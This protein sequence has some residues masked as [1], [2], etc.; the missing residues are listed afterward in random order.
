M[1]NEV[2]YL[3][4]ECQKIIVEAGQILKSARRKDYRIILK[5]ENEFITE[6]DLSVQKY[7]VNRINSLGNYNF[8]LEEQRKYD[9]NQKIENCFVIDPIDGTHNFIAG[10]PNFSTA[11]SYLDEGVVQFA[12][13]HIPENG[14]TYKAYINRGAYKNNKKLKVSE[15][16]DIKKSIIA[17]D[18]QFHKGEGI[19]RNYENL[20]KSV[21]TTRILGSACID[22]CYVSDGVID[23]RILNST[24]IYDI[25]AGSRIVQEAGGTVTDFNGEK[26]NFCKVKS[27]ILSSGMF[28]D[29]LL[30][31]IA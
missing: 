31:I 2:N 1:N 12:I 7:I 26:I 13:I 28:H 19:I 23:A 6:L 5:D 16:S 14:D 9:V 18:N 30:K 11:I 15:N 29:K 20:V 22:S 24:K 27:V 25:A 4:E 21:F 8:I 10:L 3:Y 17:Y